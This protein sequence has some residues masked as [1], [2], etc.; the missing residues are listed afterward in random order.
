MQTHPVFDKIPHNKP[1]S[2][3]KQA[4]DKMSQKKHLIPYQHFAR[5]MILPL[6][7]AV[8]NLTGVLK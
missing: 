2:V 1:D 6:S 8:P 5:S 4:Y 7:M 3:K